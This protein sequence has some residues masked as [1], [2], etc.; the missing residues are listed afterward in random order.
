MDKSFGV[1][2]CW[3]SLVLW[4]TGGPIAVSATTSAADG[5]GN[6][7]DLAQQADLIVDAVAAERTSVWIDG[8]LY[9][10]VRLEIL[11]VVAG[12]PPPTTIL[13]LPGG[14]DLDREIPVAVR[15]PGAPELGTGERALLFLDRGSVA[16]LGGGGRYYSI[17]GFSRG[18]LAIWS[19]GETLMVEEPSSASGAARSLASVATEIRDRLALRHG[20]AP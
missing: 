2:L 13:L 18:K 7:A 8:A 20:G 3:G 10:A 12:A 16:P 19:D 15:W 4:L 1:W 17:V 5:L 14:V 6:L 11:D 9:T